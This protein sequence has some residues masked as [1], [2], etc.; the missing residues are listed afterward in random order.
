MSRKFQ[1]G[2]KGNR[3]GPAGAR[4]KGRKRGGGRMR[5]GRY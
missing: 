2:K 4:M 5:G 3:K 1:I